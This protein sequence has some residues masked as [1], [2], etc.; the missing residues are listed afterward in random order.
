MMKPNITLSDIVGFVAFRKL[1]FTNGYH[2]RKIIQVC[3]SN[4][5]IQILVQYTYISQKN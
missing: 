2:N 3:T 1:R 5:N 4:I